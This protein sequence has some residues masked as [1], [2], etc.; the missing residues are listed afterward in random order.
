MCYYPNDEK[1]LLQPHFLRCDHQ[2]SSA[3]LKK[4]E[5]E[6]IFSTNHGQNYSEGFDILLA[7]QIF[8]HH[9]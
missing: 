6:D 8:S 1:T 5:A 9:K 4:Y 2:G 7:E 3:F